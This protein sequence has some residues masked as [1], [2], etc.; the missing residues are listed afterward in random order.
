MVQAGVDPIVIDYLVNHQTCAIGSRDVI[1]MTQ[2]GLTGEQIIAVIE[3][4]RCRKPED[5]SVYDEIAVIERL[6]QAG[7]SDEAILQY[8]DRLRTRHRVDTQGRTV[9]RYGNAPDRPPYPVEGSQL[10]EKKALPKGDI[11][12]YEGQ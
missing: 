9:E 5:A 6:K 10:P 4:D 11:L 2:A 3:T 1:R 12:I 8:L 7:L